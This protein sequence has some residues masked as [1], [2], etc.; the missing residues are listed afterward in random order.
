MAD[1]T[2]TESPRAGATSKPRRVW[3]APELMAREVSTSELGVAGNIDAEGL[4]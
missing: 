2:T 4:S 3:T 1:D